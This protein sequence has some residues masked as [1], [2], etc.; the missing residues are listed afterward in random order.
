M[1]FT[2]E[3]MIKAANEQVDRMI[4]IDLME[5]VYY[6]QGF[7]DGAT[8]AT[9]KF[10]EDYRFDPCCHKCGDPLSTEELICEDCGEEA[11]QCKMDYF[12]NGRKCGNCGHWVGESFKYCDDCGYKFIKE[13]RSKK[14]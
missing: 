4:G 7:Y 10:E 1:T 8:L 12:R 13:E 6:V 9:E 11:R 5:A 14:F 2:S 3:E